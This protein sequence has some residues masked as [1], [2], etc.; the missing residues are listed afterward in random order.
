MVGLVRVGRFS[1]PV[2]LITGRF[3]HGTRRSTYPGT[4]QSVLIIRSKYFLVLRLQ[5]FLILFRH[6]ASALGLWLCPLKIAIGQFYPSSKA[7]LPRPRDA[8]QRG[9]V[10]ITR[11]HLTLSTGGNTLR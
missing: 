10:F 5:E 2:H 1:R 3:S 7:I 8:H 11:G 4:S 9:C 6:E